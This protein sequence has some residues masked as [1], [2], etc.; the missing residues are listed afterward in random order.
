MKTEKEYTVFVVDDSE[1]YRAL[2]LKTLESDKAVL[3]S[4]FKIKYYAF[5]SGEE[6]IEKMWNL[7][8]DIAVIDYHLNSAGYEKNMNRLQ[9]IKYVNAKYPE[10]DIIILSSQKN[11]EVVKELLH[12]GVHEY[13]KKDITA[14]HRVKETIKKLLLIKEQSENKIEE[15]L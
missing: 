14:L 8:P 10:T 9:L 1:V 6:F 2:I 7:H 3:G 11:V 13:I 4:R 15:T 12:K 5:A